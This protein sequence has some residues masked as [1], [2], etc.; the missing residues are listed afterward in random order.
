MQ[1]DWNFIGVASN[2]FTVGQFN[3]LADGLA[4]TGNFT[5]CADHLLEWEVRWPLLKAEVEKLKPDVLC[6]QELNKPESFS[7]LL[8]GHSMLYC[9]KLASPAQDAGA[10]PDGCAMFI[11]RSLFHILDAQVFYYSNLD[12][13]K[14]KSAGGIVVG[15]KDLRN[16]EGLVF[17]TTHLKAKEKPEFELIRHDQLNQLLQRVEGM[18]SMV[19]GCT[20]TKKVNV[21]LTG[22]FN[23]PPHESCYALMRQRKFD[24]LYNANFSKSFYNKES[25]PLEEY[26]QG[27]PVFTTMKVREKMVSR[28]IDYIWLQCEGP[29]AGESVF[30]GIIASGSGEENE[31]EQKQSPEIICE[32]LYSLPSVEDVGE[33]GLPSAHYASDHLAIGTIFAWKS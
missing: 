8:S 21:I 7:G 3:V 20:N 1:R 29:K 24:S 11:N 30:D 28:T 22:D 19:S 14:P 25:I 15:V 26:L 5:R 12:I 6:I 33:D 13:D 18:K 9:P 2:S 32:A 10:T 27:E 31:E 16:G 17:A 4:Q 23:S